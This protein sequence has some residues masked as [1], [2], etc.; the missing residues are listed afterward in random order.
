VIQESHSI[1]QDLVNLVNRL[2]LVSLLVLEIQE[3]HSSLLFL[4][5]Q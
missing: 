1:Q 2:I 5:D 4:E 3:I